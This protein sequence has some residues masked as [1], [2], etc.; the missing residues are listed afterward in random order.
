MKFAIIIL[1]N[2]F[3]SL[4]LLARN[5]DKIVI[6]F[7]AKIS[8]VEEVGAKL[9]VVK[10]TVV[11]NNIKIDSTIAQN[12]RCILTLDTGYVYKIYFQKSGYVSKHLLVN[13]KELPTSFSKKST[14]KVDM[15]LFKAK[16]NLD[17][18]FLD[19]KPIGIASYNF[20]SK[21]IQPGILGD[22][23]ADCLIFN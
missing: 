23:I 4:I 21:K 7:D 17:L 3:T 11:R 15:S 12:G 6:K 9:N 20:V 14:I 8:S 22:C 5:T 19:T 10:V 1:F 18:S 2:L 16:S 13:T